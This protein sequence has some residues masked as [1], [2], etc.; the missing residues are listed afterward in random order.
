MKTRIIDDVEVDLER[1]IISIK[2]VLYVL[3]LDANLL[4][5]AAL[6]R[7]GFTV[8]FNKT[9]IEIKRE[10]IF[11]VIEIMRGRRYF[12]KTIN[13][14]FLITEREETSISNSVGVIMKASKL[15]NSN[16][17]PSALIN[18]TKNAC[19]L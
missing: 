7:R 11:I 14:T 3:E 12:L 19:R 1:R 4:S 5:I 8:L 17:I 15:S 16:E 18:Q 9:E 2:N 10:N 13:T 6:N